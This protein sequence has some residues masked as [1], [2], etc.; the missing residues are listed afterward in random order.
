MRGITFGESLSTSLITFLWNFLIPCFFSHRLRF[1]SVVPYRCAMNLCVEPFFKSISISD[2]TCPAYT[3]PSP[4][5]TGPHSLLPFC[6]QCLFGALWDEVSQD[7]GCHRK[8]HC[9]NFRLNGPVKLP[10]V[11]HRVDP[12]LSIE[13]NGENPHALQHG[14]PK[15]RQLTDDDTV[16]FF[17]VADYRSD[18][19]PLPTDFATRFFFD[20]FNIPQLLLIGKFFSLARWRMSA[21]FFEVLVCGWNSQK[22]NLPPSLRQ[23][24]R[25]FKQ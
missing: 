19:P 13:C 12:D 20:P 3:S 23:Q 1:A 14:T 2:R 17:D 22:L 16:P 9:D 25:R 6:K 21:F 18:F 5:R 15:T 10:V 8:R 24:W 7:V 11:F 4:D